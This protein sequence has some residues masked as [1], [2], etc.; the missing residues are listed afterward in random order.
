MKEI[1]VQSRSLIAKTNNQGSRKI[2]LFK[3]AKDFTEQYIPVTDLNEFSKGFRDYLYNGIKKKSGIKSVGFEQLMMLHDIDSDK[4]RTLEIEFKKLDNIKLNKDFTEVAPFDA[5][6]Y[7]ETPQELEKLKQFKEVKKAV[8]K[9]EKAGIKV[10]Y[11][12]L[13]RAFHPLTE[14]SVGEILPNVGYIKGQNIM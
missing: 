10:N 8:D 3:K 5:G 1:I 2:I 4:L 11:S 7:A 13:S 6:I 14:L 9:L 12:Y